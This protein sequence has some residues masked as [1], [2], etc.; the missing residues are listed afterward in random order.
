MAENR[1]VHYQFSLLARAWDFHRFI[2][3]FTLHMDYPF[4]LLNIFFMLFVCLMPFSTSLI[5]Q[6]PY[7]HM[8]GM[9]YAGNWVAL[10]SFLYWMWHHATRNHRLIAKDIEPVAIAWG[11]KRIRVVTGMYLA[12][13]F[14]SLFSSELSVLW[15]FLRQIVL[16]LVPLFIQHH[17]REFKT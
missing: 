6:Y 13:F 4:L 7:L 2:F 1:G 9:V 8:A 3:H 12:A 11:F 16:L 5:S 10:A 17:H 15:I 14:I